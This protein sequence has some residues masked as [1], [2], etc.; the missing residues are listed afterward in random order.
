MANIRLVQ[1]ARMFG[2][3]RVEDERAARSLITSRPGDFAN[4]IFAEAA[5]NDDV[6]SQRAALEYLEGRLAEFSGLV[7]DEGAVTSAFVTRLTAW[8]G[9]ES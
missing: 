6:T 1:L 2:L 5:D 4:A 3:P 8:D 9:A 7:Q